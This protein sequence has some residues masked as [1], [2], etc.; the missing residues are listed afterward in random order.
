[1][2]YGTGGWRFFASG[3]GGSFTS[4][5][6]DNGTLSQ[7]GGTYTYTT[8]DGETW[9]FNSSGYETGWSSPDG[10]SLLTYTYNGSNHLATMTAIDGTMTT[11][12]YSGGKVSTIV[13]GNN[14]TTTLAYSGSNLTQVTNPDGGVETFSYDAQP[15][16]DG[17]DLRQPPELVGLWQQRRAGD[18]DLGQQRQPQRDQ[19]LAGRGAGAEPR[20]CGRCTAQETDPT[21]DVTQW[22]LDGQ[23]R[24]LQETA[25]NG[26][27]TT[28][29]RNAN[30]YVTS[31]TDPDGR[32]TT[33]A[34]DTAGYTTQVTNPGR[35]HCRPTST[36]SQLPRPHQVDRRSATRRRPTP[37][38]ARG[39]QTSTTDALG[40][41]TT[42]TYLTNGR[43]ADG[44]RSHAATSRPTLTTPC[45]D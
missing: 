14:R 9:T 33:Y 5:A 31:T 42:S 44:D 41:I 7:T 35:Q 20:R 4:P 39:H 40:D 43:L 28:W 37:T 29:A 30:G 22:Q 19:L 38:T 32:T 3:G 11:F 6:G 1:M 25:A 15:P 27:V 36:R 23:G 26:G 12:N 45:A 34:L 18:D 24:P 17:R 2:A 16:P 21:G 10:Q 8:P 13:T